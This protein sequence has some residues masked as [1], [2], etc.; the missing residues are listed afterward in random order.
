M[1]KS[2]YIIVIALLLLTVIA[3]FTIPVAR[4]VGTGFISKLDL[5]ES[6]NNWH[7]KD[8]SSSLN[9]DF[10][11]DWNKFISEALIYEYINKAGNR[12]N[13]II[14]DAGNFHNPKV[15]FTASGFEIEAL[16]DTELNIA[17]RSIKAKTLFTTKEN[18]SNLSLYWIIIDKKISQ[19]WVEQKIKQLYFSLFN[20]KRVGLMV[21]VDIPTERDNMK[22]AL[23]IATQFMNDLGSQFNNEQASYIFGNE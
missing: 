20:R 16:P 17:G 1:N 2:K 15:C 8:I 11:K 14:L 13:F 21:R 7:G 5:P 22:Q 12:L 23:V 19:N 6:M 3:S 9:L 18:Q 10:D 4:Y